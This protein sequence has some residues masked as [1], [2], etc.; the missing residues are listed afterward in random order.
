MSVTHAPAQAGAPPA[1]TPIAQTQA[2]GL[3]FAVEPLSP[4]ESVRGE[5]TVDASAS[6]S[7]S[8]RERGRSAGL[9]QLGQA[10]NFSYGEPL[11]ARCA[12][13]QETC[14]QNRDIYVTLGDVARIAAH[15]GRNGF[16]EFRVPADPA[17]LDQDDDP[18]WRDHVTRADSSR[19]V[20]RQVA[21]GDCT[22]LGEAG[23]SLPGEIRPLVCRLYPFDYDGQGVKQELTE[24]CP[25]ELLKPGTELLDELNMHRADAERWQRQ[26]YEEI[27]GERPDESRPDL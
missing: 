13:H 3:T 11:C 6:N 8:P 16:Y 4:R 7:L 5:G 27:Q 14:C 20:L 10:A 25:L 12:R 2:D 23:C 1:E 21:N 9:V 15:T 22:F 26:L 17:Y 18:V 19:R 24:G